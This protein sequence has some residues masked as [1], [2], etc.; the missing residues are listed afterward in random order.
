SPANINRQAGS[1]GGIPPT[2]T[3]GPVSFTDT[4]T[5]TP[6]LV[7]ELYTISLRSTAGATISPG[8]PVSVPE[9]TSLAILGAGLF[10]LGLVRRRQR[11]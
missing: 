7:G 10:G 2:G 1:A 5:S 6:L 9:P 4:F 8:E 3:I 11:N